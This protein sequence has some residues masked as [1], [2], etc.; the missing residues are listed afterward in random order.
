MKNFVM[1]IVLLLNIVQAE[2]LGVNEKLGEYVPLDL[3]F[4]D[5]N[6]KSRTLKEYMDGK[7][8]ILSLNYFRCGGDM[9]STARRYG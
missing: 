1:L 7:P 2:S 8:T 9:W 5:E 4:I 3:T 6:G